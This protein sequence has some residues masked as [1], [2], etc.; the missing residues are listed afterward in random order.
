MK[1]EKHRKYILLTVLVFTLSSLLL[2]SC[3]FPTSSTT[4]KGY[5]R[6]DGKPVANAEVSFGGAL[7][8]TQTTTDERG[9]Y[10]VTARHRPTQ[11][12]Y[13][14]IK[15]E[16]FAEQTDKFPGFA[17]PEGDKNIELMKTIPRT[18]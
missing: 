6:Y 14:T 9:F 10:T 7:G 1:P 16:G 8:A 11:M 15:K 4:V 13:L 3:I 12:L 17:A 18:R 2:T 5:V